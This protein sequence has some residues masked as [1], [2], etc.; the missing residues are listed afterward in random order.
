MYQAQVKAHFDSAHFLKGY[1]G[2]CEELHGHRFLVAVT[3]ETSELDE[4]GMSVDFGIMKKHLKEI[5]ERLDHTN[6]NDVTPFDRIN[7]SSEN[8]AR[9]IFEEMKQKFVQYI[10]SGA[11]KFSVKKVKIWESPDTW[12]CYFE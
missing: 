5:V 12:A 7:P 9:H 8:I 4:V 3:I 10:D 1:K 2:K 11:G 6:L